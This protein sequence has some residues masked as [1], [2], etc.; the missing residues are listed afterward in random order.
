MFVQTKAIAYFV[1]VAVDK[2]LVCDRLH[3]FTLYC[4]IL[5]RKYVKEIITKC[6]ILSRKPSSGTFLQFDAVC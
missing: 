1:T 6:A 3:S 5:N 4:L 2:R